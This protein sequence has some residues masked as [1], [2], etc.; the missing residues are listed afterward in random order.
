MTGGQLPGYKFSFPDTKYLVSKKK[1]N[2]FQYYF[3][4]AKSRSPES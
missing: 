2:A 4:V 3:N 1:S